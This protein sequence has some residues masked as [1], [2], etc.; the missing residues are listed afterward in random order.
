MEVSLL[1]LPLQVRVQVAAA[2]AEMEVVAPVVVRVEVRVEVLL[3]L[4][5]V[6]LL[7]LLQKCSSSAIVVLP[8]ISLGK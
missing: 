6:A 3:P 1:L 2:L 7:V 5:R 4:R 8:M